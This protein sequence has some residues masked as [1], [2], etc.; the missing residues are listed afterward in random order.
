MEKEDAL[1]QV[2]N[3][4]SE[5]LSGIERRQEND[6]KEMIDKISGLEV[7]ISDDKKEMIDKISGLEIN[8]SDN[9]KETLERISHLETN[10]NREFQ[11]ISTDKNEILDRITTLETNNN[12]EF[13]NITDSF[14]YERKRLD[15]IHENREKIKVKWS[16]KIMALNTSLAAFVAFIVSS[17]K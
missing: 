5:R 8:I 2:L 10:N 11:R 15:E 9:K 3:Q 14:A 4:I 16:T 7:K 12:R 6:K 13:Q 17:F 1:V